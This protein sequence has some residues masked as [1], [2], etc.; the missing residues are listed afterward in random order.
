MHRG[1]PDYLAE[2]HE[3]FHGLRVAASELRDGDERLDIFI[4]VPEEVEEP[5]DP[6]A[7]GPQFR[8][9]LWCVAFRV[10]EDPLPEVH[11]RIEAAPP[12]KEIWL[13]GKRARGRFRD[14][15]WDG[16]DCHVEAIGVW[17][18]KARRYVYY[19]TAESGWASRVAKGVLKKTVDEALDLG[20]EILPIP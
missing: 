16:P 10:E 17:H 19:G 18:V 12:E 3:V 14:I 4:G 1:G 20:K 11:E 7:E 6:L 15:W 9:I 5:V 13:Y 2:K 8:E